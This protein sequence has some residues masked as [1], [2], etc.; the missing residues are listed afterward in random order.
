VDVAVADGSAA[1]VRAELIGADRWL[2][3]RVPH[4][5]A[6]DLVLTLRRAG[7]VLGSARAAT[8]NLPPLA[9]RLEL[10]GHGTIDFLPTNR[11]ARVLAPALEGGALVPIPMVGA[12][13]VRRDPATGSD[14]VRG[15]DG[16]AGSV[17]L[18]FAVRDPALPAGLRDLALAEVAEPVERAIRVANLAVALGASAESASPL[19][20]LRC[21]DGHARVRRMSPGVTTAIP[22]SARDT[23]RLVLHRERLQLEDGAQELV[24]SIGVVRADG[25]EQR[26]RS[27]EQRVVLRRA[28]DPLILYVSGVR[29]PFDRVLVRIALADDESHYVTSPG[30][31]LG[32]TEAQ[33]TVICGTDH[34]RILA[35]AAF[36]TGL[37]RASFDRTHDGVLALNAGALL[38]FVWLSGDGQEFP[39][40]LETGVM[41]LGVAGDS[42]IGNAAGEVAVVAGVGIGVPIANSGRVSQTSIALHAW[43][44]YEVS[45]AFRGDPAGSPWAFI[46]GP[47]ISIGDVGAS[48]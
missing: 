10:S 18:R 46:F 31:Q 14:L 35:T 20:E 5:D 47:S 42:A 17:A 26:E 9:V 48:F 33:W 4:V 2:V 13:D 23:C 22:F 43:V 8:R 34:V 21:G 12:Y 38:R 24:V 32:A 40:G 30:E 44:E 15:V 3:V 19:V 36:P 45:R 7:T 25:S 16:A 41:W 39:L 11:E 6:A 29:D 28:A 1:I 37:Y 27:R